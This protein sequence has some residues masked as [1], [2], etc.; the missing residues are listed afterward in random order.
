MRHYPAVLTVVGLTLIAV[1]CESAP[2]PP[3]PGSP[4]FL[5][6][7]AKST[8]GQGD[9]LKASDNLGTLARGESEF[10]PRA[11]PL[12][13]V[14]TTG[15]AQAYIDLSEN[16]EF[17][18]R[19]N[20]ANPAPF[21]RQSQLVR[22]YASTSALQTAETLH[23]FLGTPA[24]KAES[25]VYEFPFPTGGANEPV[26]L[27][28]VSKGILFPDAEMEALQ[29][30]M[31]QRGVLRAVLRATGAGEDPAKGLEMFKAGE[32]K[33]PRATFYLGI[34]RSLYD[35]ADLFGG[36]KLDQPNRI[37]MLCG[38]AEEALKAIPESKETKE[39]Q[40]KIT[41]MVKAIK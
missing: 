29:K 14:L 22:G 18:A 13:I 26:G 19:A 24:G 5:W 33:I 23:K 30:A 1:G 40:A 4:A 35:Q 39:L 3:Q 41:K 21:R 6:G 20:R 7:A 34:A 17:G 31:I 8:Y 36:K 37:K 16:L 15:I 28:R 10:A 27:Q 25:I 12:S 11:M 9:F 2:A 32:V 38:Q